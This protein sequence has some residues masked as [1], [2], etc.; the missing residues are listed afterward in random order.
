M[1]KAGFANSETAG[2]GGDKAPTVGVPEVASIKGTHV[3]ISRISGGA[4]GATCVS[5]TQVLNL[6]CFTWRTFNKNSHINRGL[7]A[8]FA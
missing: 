2:I 7:K 1:D 3:V 8:H 4:Y 5:S 6:L